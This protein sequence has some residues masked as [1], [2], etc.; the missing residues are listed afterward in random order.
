[1]ESELRIPANQARH[2]IE[3]GRAFLVCAYEE[4]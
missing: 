2:Q 4:E 3:S 1:M